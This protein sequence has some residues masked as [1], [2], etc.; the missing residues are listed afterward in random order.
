MA[1]T[2]LDDA[3]ISWIAR[4][5]HD[6]GFNMTTGA[7]P[8]F[9]SGFAKVPTQ[10]MS[11][12][13]RAM[14]AIA[15]GKN[16]SRTQR[17]GLLIPLGAMYGLTGFGFEKHADYAAEVLGIAPE[18]EWNN[19]I[20]FGVVDTVLEMTTGLDISV[21]Q[22]MAPLR[23]IKDIYADI[24]EGSFAEAIAGPSGAI[25]HSITAQAAET[26][27]NMIHQRPYALT[28][29]SLKVLRQPAGVNNVFKA[30]GIWNRGVLTSKNGVVLREG[31]TSSDAITHALGFNTQTQAEIQQRRTESYYRWKKD[32]KFRKNMNTKADLALS[33][34]ASDDPDLEAHG[35]ALLEEVRIQVMNAIDA[36]PSFID[37]STDIYKRTAMPWFQLMKNEYRRNNPWGIKRLRHIEG[38]K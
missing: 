32:N 21:A 30:Y 37:L 13:F 7:R 20:R 31:M 28:E 24:K 29:S 23:I 9:Q 18:S 4:K 33:Y 8:W 3:A 10:W 6:L 12:S 36:D 25:A 35:H 26:I 1:K 11:Y 19:V 22:R 16:L 27:G 34:L 15:F 17:A 2:I 5:E 38:D 14:E